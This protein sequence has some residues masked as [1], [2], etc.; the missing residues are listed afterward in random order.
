MLG[1]VSERKSLE[2]A[3]YLSLSRDT[4]YRMSQSGKIPATKVGS[5]WR[6]DAKEIED[7]LK[8]N[9]NTSQKKS[10]KIQRRKK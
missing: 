3:G 4:V 8:N 5:Q 7:W 2:V 6:F 10:S 9:K 1:A